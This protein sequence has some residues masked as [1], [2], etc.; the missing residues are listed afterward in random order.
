MLFPIQ[1]F[2]LHPTVNSWRH[3]HSY[4][5]ER[6][7]GVQRPSFLEKAVGFHRCMLNCFVERNNVF[8][9]YRFLSKKCHVYILLDCKLHISFT[10]LYVFWQTP[11]KSNN[12][13]GAEGETTSFP[14]HYFINTLK[15]QKGSYLLLPCWEIHENAC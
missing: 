13:G 5:S 14:R 7:I 2:F 1:W 9:V 6:Q 15:M 11:E 10:I 3:D 4:P 8:I 12:L